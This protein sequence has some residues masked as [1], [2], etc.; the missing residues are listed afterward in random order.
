MVVLGEFKK[1]K[2]SLLNALLNARVCPTDPDIAT[3]IPNYLRFGAEFGV[4]ALTDDLAETGTALPLAAAEAVARG[5]AG[6]VR[7]LEIRLPREL[8]SVGIVL[9]DTPGVGGGLA[10]SHAATALRALARAGV[11]LFVADAGS[12]YSAPELELLAQAVKICPNVVCAVTKTDMYPQWRRIVEAD[13]AHLARVKITAPMVPVS[14]PLRLAGLLENDDELIAESGFPALTSQLLAALDNAAATG[15]ASAAAVVLSVLGQIRFELNARR[16]TLTGS[17]DDLARRETARLARQRAQ[18]LRGVGARW[19]VVLNER[20]DDLFA[21]IELDLTQRLRTLRAAAAQ[22]IAS[23]H[24]SR[25]SADLGPWLQQ[26]TNEVLVAHVRR[27]QDEVESVADAVA[28]QFGSASWELRSGMEFGS[29]RVDPRTS[30][31]F[32]RGCR[33]SPMTRFEV[34]LAAL[35]GGAT[36]AMRGL[37]AVGL[38]GRDRGA[39]GDPGRA[40]AV[41]GARREVVAVRSVEPGSGAAGG[42]DSAVRGAIS[43]GGH[44]GAQGLS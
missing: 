4:R 14:S 2:S 9:V 28:D 18:E 35:R 30:A 40:G 22:H 42:G 24:P 20:L 32:G 10:S 41:R 29:T 39:G 5:Q 33:R 12:E 17:A 37:D 15:Q 23:T 16:R 8:L 31:E 27:L 43:R 3:A 21:E 11:V 7:A 25:L 6:D 19:Q 36:G 34:G 13:R 26:Q 44:R 1:G 38:G